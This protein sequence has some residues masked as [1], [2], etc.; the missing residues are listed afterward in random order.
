MRLRELLREAVAD[1]TGPTAL[2]FP[3]AQTGREI[4]SVGRIGQADVLRAHVD[5]RVLLVSVGPLAEPALAAADLLADAGVAATVVDPRWVLP[6]EPAL[7]ELATAY[8][9]VV[10]VEDGVVDG[11]VGDAVARAVR[12]LGA[13]TRVVS[14]GLAKAFVPHGRR[15][16]ILADAGLDAAGIAAA[17]LATADLAEAQPNRRASLR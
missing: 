12:D 13:S 6:V 9:L 2:R 8:D 3:K 17:A 16:D 7:A 14:L 4:D 11:G 15:A 10:T 5:A 1:D